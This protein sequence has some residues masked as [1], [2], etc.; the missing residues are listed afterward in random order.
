MGMNIPSD[1]CIINEPPL[2]T[3]KCKVMSISR[4][5]VPFLQS[6]H[7]KKSYL[8]RVHDITDLSVIFDST[9]SFNKYLL[10]TI[11]KSSMILGSFIRSCFYYVYIV[12]DFTNP[13]VL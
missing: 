5:Q 8:I 13:V 9:L 4:F 3:K 1:W 2:N 7:I 10:H 12:R 11:I 6:Y